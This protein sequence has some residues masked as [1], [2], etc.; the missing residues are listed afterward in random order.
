MVPPSEAPTAWTRLDAAAKHERVL[1]VAGE[2]FAREGVGASMPALADALGVGVGSIYRQ[3]GPK[4]DIVAALVLGRLRRV[5]ARLEAAAAEPDAW[6]ALR[7]ATHDLVEEAVC[8]G[9]SRE[10]WAL[11]AT[12]PEVR[13]AR[14]AVIAGLDAVI[15]RAH[16]QGALRADV[17]TEDLRLVLQ[18]AKAVDFEGDA[19]HR[20]VELALR[21]MRA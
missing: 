18:T 21:G 9:L 14:P 3:V 17:T 4:E 10:L 13:A 20:L 6:L 1:E 19:A 7:E 11:G 8:D 5:A 16:E 12:H 2:L 15:D